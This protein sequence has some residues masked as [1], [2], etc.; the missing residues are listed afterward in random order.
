MEILFNKFYNTSR[1]QE[2][3]RVQDFILLANRL[4]CYRFLDARKKHVPSRS[5]IKD[6]I[7]HSKS[8]NQ[9]FVFI[10][11]GSPCAPSPM[12]LSEWAHHGDVC[13]PVCC[14]IQE[15]NTQLEEFTTPIAGEVSPLWL[16]GDT[17]LSLK[18][19]CCICNNPKK[20]HKQRMI[21]AL[22]SW[23]TWLDHAGHGI[24]P[25]P[26]ASRTARAGKT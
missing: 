21:R 20:W 14:I 10:C 1:Y 15:R 17:T 9:S 13:T 7:I 6:V 12:E 4:S 24:L 2:L 16:A 5:E 18:V 22:H 11:T 19:A 26:T 25:L 8:S 3:C 23:H